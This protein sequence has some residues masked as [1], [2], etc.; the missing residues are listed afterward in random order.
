MRGQSGGHHRPP[1]V[2]SPGEVSSRTT[3]VLMEGAR[4]LIAYWFHPIEQSEI[5]TLP[6]N[7]LVVAGRDL[8]VCPILFAGCERAAGWRLADT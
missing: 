3:V 7:I 8:V 4:K 2:S 6:C 5:H 1:C